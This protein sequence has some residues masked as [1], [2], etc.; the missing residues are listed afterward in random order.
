MP[1]LLLV[2]LLVALAGCSG[3]PADSGSAETPRKPRPADTP[4]KSGSGGDTP[5]R[6][7]APASPA[8]TRPGKGARTLDAL[9]ADLRQGDEGQRLQ[10]ARELQQ[11]GQGAKDAAPDLATLAATSGPGELR[12]AAVEALQAIYPNHADDLRALVLDDAG[13]RIAAEKH[14]TDTADPPALAPLTPILDWRIASLPEEAKKANVGY[15]LAGQE[16]AALVPLRLKAAPLDD[17]AF[18]AVVACAET[19]PYGQPLWQPAQLTLCDIAKQDKDRRKDALSA[20]NRSLAQRIAVPTIRRVG[21]LGP[22]AKELE[23][24]LDLLTSDRNED[25]RKAAA[26]ALTKVRG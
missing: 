16:Y 19:N 2:P 15:A 23:K 3:G 18:K 12:K 4:P 6:G 20:L 24:L 5:P 25:V 1:R 7:T 8:D 17:A 13:K 11:L 26:E 9:R 22:D 10:A 21:D 14:L